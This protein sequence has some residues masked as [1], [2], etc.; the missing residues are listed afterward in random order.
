MASKVTFGLIV[1]LSDLY[2][3]CNNASLASLCKG[4][5][6][7]RPR[8]REAYSVGP[9]LGAYSRA[10]DICQ[11]ALGQCVNV[12]RAAPAFGSERYSLVSLTLKLDI[13]R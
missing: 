13:T 9:T 8:I 6:I 5:R 10:G 4:L 1:K 7:L 12:K 3:L 11:V 2:H